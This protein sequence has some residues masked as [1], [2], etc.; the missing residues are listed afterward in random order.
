MP[1]THTNL[2]DLLR[3]ARALCASDLHLRAGQVPWQALDDSPGVAT[4][5]LGVFTERDIAIGEAAQPEALDEGPAKRHHDHGDPARSLDLWPVFEKPVSGAHVYCCGP[6]GL[7]DSVRDM[8]G[9]W[10]TSAV[11]FEAF[12]DG[13]TPRPEDVPFTVKIEKTGEVLDVPVGVS[14]L[15]ALRNAGHP[16]PSS[17]ES[18]SC[19]SCRTRLVSGDV[20][21]RDFVL[22]PGEYATDIMVCV[23]RAK[24][25]ELVLEL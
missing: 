9:H 22:T 7:M 6:Q 20:D 24:T 12:A 19:G 4:R 2:T 25:T 17:C 16:V 3:Q 11:H 5:F 10:S 13:S 14:I 23:S 21:H 8:T 18:G 15:E 1:S